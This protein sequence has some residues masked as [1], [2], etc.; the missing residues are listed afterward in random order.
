MHDKL[1][2]L[3]MQCRHLNYTSFTACFEE[4]RDAWDAG[5]RLPYLAGGL[6]ALIAFLVGAYA[7]Y[8]HHTAIMGAV[9]TYFHMAEPI[10]TEAAAVPAETEIQA[11]VEVSSPS[12]RKTG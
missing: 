6:A 4:H 5:E 1:E 8:R 7:I 2:W 11:S 10:A 3:I 9:H 12:M